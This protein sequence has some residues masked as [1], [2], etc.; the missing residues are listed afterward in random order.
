MLS[1]VLSKNLVRGS[2]TMSRMIKPE[3]YTCFCG[4]TDGQ[5]F[6]R[7]L[8]QMPRRNFQGHLNLDSQLEL[9]PQEVPKDGQVSLWKDIE[10]SQNTSLVLKSDDEIENYVLSIVRSYFRTTR[11]ASVSLDST[12]EEHGLDS[13]DVIELVIQVEDELGYL[14]DAEKL[15]LFS[16]PRHFVNFIA[17]LESYRTEHNRLPHEGIYEDFQVKKHFPG[18][19]SMGH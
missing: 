13:L 14:I 3:G 16:R 15:E 19:P 8:V 11:K 10:T 12:F 7:S 1:R 18:L 4:C 17:Q 9:V 2:M 5:H 6:G